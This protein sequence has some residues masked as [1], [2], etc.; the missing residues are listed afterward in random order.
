MAKSVLIA[1]D[2]QRIRK[3]VK[4]YLLDNHYAVFE[5]KDGI[6]TLTAIKNEA[7]DLVLLDLM[8]PHMGGEKAISEIRKFSD[9]YVI[10]LTAKTG[11]DAQVECYRLGADDYVEKPFSCKALLSKIN[12][13]FARLD[14]KAYGRQ[15]ARVEGLIC[16]PYAR[17]AFVNGAD[18]RLKPK[19]YELLAFLMAN[20]NIAVSRE[21]ILDSV[22][23]VDYI[24]NDRTVDVH[25][26]RLRK[27]LGNLEGYISAVQGVGYMFEVRHEI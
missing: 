11:E 3:I 1:D 23:G 18:C 10:V 26:S 16:D 25:V 24:G 19:E 9:V 8:M 17:K 27:K 13:V 5:A 15:V 22:W 21:K 6:E 2:E 20:Q 14:K 4:E 7:I 12:A